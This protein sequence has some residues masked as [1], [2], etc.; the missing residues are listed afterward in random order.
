MSDTF[1]NDLDEIESDVSPPG[2][3]AVFGLEGL[4]PRKSRVIEREVVVYQDNPNALVPLEDGSMAYKR[5]VLTDHGMAIPDN[6][7]KEEWEDVGLTLKRIDNVVTW[8]IA[9][10]AAFA[11]DQWDK[12]YEEIADEYGY[13]EDTIKSYASVA[14]NVPFQLRL[15]SNQPLRFSHARELAPLVGNYGLQEAWAV[16]ITE[17]GLTVEEFKVHKWL[18]SDLMVAESWEWIERALSDGHQLPG[19][20]EFAEKLERRNRKPP[21][22]LKKFDQNAAVLKR[23]YAD[24]ERLQGKQH[25]KALQAA[26]ELRMYVDECL[27]RLGAEE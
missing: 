12:P 18:L 25:E 26:R 22:V 6:M 4:A 17:F 14:R 20:P 27:R 11:N 23:N 1:K 9:D 7:S 21:A 2:A 15:I 13:T 8:N 3:D 24:L 10:W 19:Y 5:V 16:Y